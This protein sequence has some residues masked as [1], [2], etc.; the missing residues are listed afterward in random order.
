MMNLKA[1]IK[2]YKKKQLEYN[3]IIELTKRKN[4]RITPNE[5]ELLLKKGTLG[6][7]NDGSIYLYHGGMSYIIYHQGEIIADPEDLSKLIIKYY[8][9]R[10]VD[11]DKR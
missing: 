5:M 8:R 4:I 2:H 9:L 10:R 11:N 7:G 1:K 6:Q 3:E